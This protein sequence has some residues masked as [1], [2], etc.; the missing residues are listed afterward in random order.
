M[1]TFF[2]RI[3]HDKGL[4]RRRPSFETSRVYLAAGALVASALPLS[5]LAYLRRKRSSACRIDQLLLAGEKRVAGRT[6]FHVDVTLVGRAR[7]KPGAA[8]TLHPDL[9]VIWMDS[10]FW[11]L[12]TFP[13]SLQCSEL[14]S[15]GS[16]LHS[17]SFIAIFPLFH[18]PL[19][20]RAALASGKLAIVP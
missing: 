8:C 18:L 10:L 7:F 9:F 11:H 1:E 4:R 14:R 5:D 12:E 3:P 20:W 19:S 2:I 15:Q 6:N 13:A 17:R 16:K